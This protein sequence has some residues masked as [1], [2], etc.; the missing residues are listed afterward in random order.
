M[1]KL[2]LTFFTFT[3]LYSVGAAEN[4]HWLTD[5]AKAEAQAQ[6]ENKLVLIDF[7]GSDFCPPCKLLHKTVF[8]SPEFIAFAKT[9]LVLVVADFPEYKKLPKAQVKANEALKTRFDVDGYPTVLV[10][11]SHGKV[12]S[13][14]AG[15]E[16]MSAKE[17]VANLAKL[18]S[19]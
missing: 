9:N 15:Y 14:E 10:L 13:K 16:G 11:D 2:L 5:F 3:A 6:A 4:V 19:S 18:K 1:K 12:L 17:Y 7:T 8:T